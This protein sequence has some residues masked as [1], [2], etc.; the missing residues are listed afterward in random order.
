MA[1]V[2]VHKRYA[3]WPIASPSVKYSK[4]AS[5]I[6]NASATATSPVGAASTR[7]TTSGINT[8]AV[9]TRF[10]VIE[11]LPRHGNCSEL[12]KHHNGIGFAEENEFG[13]AEITL[14]A[15][16]PGRVRFC[17]FAFADA[18]IAPIAFLE[19]HES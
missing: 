6:T 13:T 8:T 7:L 15:G 2:A 11:L 14:L 4:I 16:K 12:S 3:R 17:F 19:I 5:R 1:Q 10:Q 18:A 9:A